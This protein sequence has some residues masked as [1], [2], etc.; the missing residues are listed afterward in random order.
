MMSTMQAG[1]DEN[2]FHES[3]VQSDIGVIED[4][5]GDEN[6]AGNDYRIQRE[7]KQYQQDWCEKPTKDLFSNM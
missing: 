2:P 7:S 3:Q 4:A 5:P 6:G 1:R